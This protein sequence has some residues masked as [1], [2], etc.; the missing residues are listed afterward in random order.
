MIERTEIEEGIALEL[1][2]YVASCQNEQIFN[3][4]DVCTLIF[5]ADELASIGMEANTAHIARHN[6]AREEVEQALLMIQ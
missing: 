6:I 1:I 5:V 4:Y 2:S 3:T